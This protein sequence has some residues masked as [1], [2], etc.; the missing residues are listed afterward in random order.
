VGGGSVAGGGSSGAAG[1]GGGGVTG[2]SG[3]ATGGGGSAGSTDAGT[4]AGAQT[5]GTGAGA[6]G[7]TTAAPTGGSGGSAAAPIEDV[8]WQLDSMSPS[9]TSAPGFRE[10]DSPR[11]P[12]AL[13]GEQAAP[14]PTNSWWLGLV[15]EDGTTRL[16][17]LPYHVRATGSGLEFC[18]PQQDVQQDAVFANDGLWLE[19]GS[20][21][22]TSSRAVTEYDDLSVTMTWTGASGSMSAPIVA[23]MPY[24][25]MLYDGL[26]P[27]L[28]VAGLSGSG[29][30]FEVEVGGDSWVVY[31]SAEVTFNAGTA[32]APL[33]G[34]VRVALLPD[35]GAAAVLDAH[36]SAVVL[37]GYADL[38]TIGETGLVQLSFD[39]QGAPD[40]L[41]MALPHHLPRLKNRASM[42]QPLRLTTIKGPAQAMS[43][44]VWQL[45][46][47]L[48]QV[49]FRPP[50]PMAADLVEEVRAAL[51]ADAGENPSAD[52]SVYW[53]GKDLTKL[54]RLA[55]IAEELGETAIMNTM[56]DRL[57]SKL[58]RW[59]N[60]EN[61]GDRLAYD[62]T[63]GGVVNDCV[64][65]DP[66]CDYG[67]GVYNDHHFHYGY[68]VYAAA[69]IARL[70]P[71]WV[72]Q[73]GEKVM[74]LIRDYANPY[75]NDPY[76]TRFRAFDFYH[77]HSWAAG[78]TDFADG[79]NQESTSEAVHGYYAVQLWG[80]TTGDTD[81]EKAGAILRSAESVGAQT[82]WQIRDPSAVYAAPFASHPCVGIV[83]NTK[84]EH[85]TWFG[86]NEEYICGIQM[87]PVTPASED[88][89]SPDWVAEVWDSKLAPTAN[90]LA[91]SDGWR[92]FLASALANWD[93]ARACQMIREQTGHDSGNTK[94]NMLYYCATRP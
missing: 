1:S 80:E 7:G 76:F 86:A 74:W 84:A 46:Y 41:M 75:R 57:K 56:L 47:P 39:T 31:T 2:G 18:Y 22:G 66:D 27:A 81:L 55:L 28:D 23:G 50:R 52:G 42:E 34:W 58:E 35:A 44:S 3:G 94:T 29:T 20:V 38:A 43:G 4:G 37:R 33:D 12:T 30:R 54:A 77:G 9:D 16:A 6:T 49:S 11:A 64:L 21:E 15:L 19:L 91:V 26:T 24:V 17:P 5:G 62:R 72:D 51:Q 65:S 70:D 14:R 71:A 92:D 45:H 79:R 53:S 87:I 82:Y 40:P 32:A 63:W 88:L 60:A 10:I 59:L 89:L 48:T 68:H 85:A 8:D 67:Q 93:A 73:Y 90:A 78:L 61:A 36:A 13:W 69:V 25:T 83:W